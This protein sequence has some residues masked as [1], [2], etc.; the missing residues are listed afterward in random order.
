ME[1]IH[2]LD[3]MVVY[4]LHNGKLSIESAKVGPIDIKGSLDK[5][6][7]EIIENEVSEAVKNGS[8]EPEDSIEI[9]LEFHLEVNYSF[10]PGSKSHFAKQFGNWLPGEPP[11]VKITSVM[12]GTQDVLKGLSKEDVDKLEIKVLEHE[13]DAD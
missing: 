11:E 8:L 2:E 13:T 3:L 7:V 9:P 1:Y 10:S 4:K 6:D 5:S 12:L